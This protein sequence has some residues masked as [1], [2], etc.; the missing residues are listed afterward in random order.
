MINSQVETK[1]GGIATVFL[2]HRVCVAM[3]G[4]VRTCLTLTQFVLRS[5]R[6]MQTRELPASVAATR[7]TATDFATATLSRSTIR[8]ALSLCG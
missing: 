8:I 4:R 7:L 6:R 5:T 3:S 2:T 1:C